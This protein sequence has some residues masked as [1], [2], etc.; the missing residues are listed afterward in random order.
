MLTTLYHTSYTVMLLLRKVFPQNTLLSFHLL[1]HKSQRSEL[2]W[3]IFLTL[4]LVPVVQ[5][6]PFCSVITAFPFKYSK[7]ALT[8]CASTGL[9]VWNMLPPMILHKPS[10]G[11]LSV[12][13]Q[14]L[15]WLSLVV[16]LTTSELSRIHKRIVYLWE[17]FCLVLG[18]WI[19]F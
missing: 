3:Y 2:S 8:C 7:H 14:Y 11:F 1:Q 19:H 5:C 15:R 6:F 16:N 18:G 10:L 13:W 9:Y 17:V 4:C 12:L